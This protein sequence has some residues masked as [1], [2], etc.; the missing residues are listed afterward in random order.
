MKKEIVWIWHRVGEG[1][2]WVTF[3]L[4]PTEIT[5]TGI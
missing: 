2:N 4:Y 1:V 3:A 5:Y